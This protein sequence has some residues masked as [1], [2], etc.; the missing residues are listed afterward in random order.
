MNFLKILTGALGLSHLAQ[1]SSESV[2]DDARDLRGVEPFVDVP[3]YEIKSILAY[4]NNARRR[5]QGN[6][7]PPASKMRMV[8][9]NYELQQDLKNFVANTDQSWF[10]SKNQTGSRYNLENITAFEPFKSKYG[11]NISFF[12]HDSCQSS[13]VAIRRI[14]Y[15]RAY[16]QRDC[17]NYSACTD[18]VTERKGSINGYMSCNRYPYPDKLL[19][20]THCSWFWQYYP[21]IVND[22][23]KEIA[24]ALLGFQGPD[25]AGTGQL[26][27]FMCYYTKIDAAKKQT[28]EIPYTAG[29]ACSE[30][31]PSSKCVNRLCV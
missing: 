1:S 22:N 31:P 26:N 9:W 27:H 29:P 18:F 20:S 12:I 2:L 8:T 6:A 15:Y 4:T 24:C 5:T 17:F 14:F 23:V 25:A 21:M 16:A 11:E 7:Q 30:C 3:R 13:P 10:F 28:T 19:S